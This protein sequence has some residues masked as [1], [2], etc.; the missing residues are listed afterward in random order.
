MPGLSGTADGRA[1]RPD[2]PDSAGSRYRAWRRGLLTERLLSLACRICQALAGTGCDRDNPDTGTLVRI[3]RDPP[4]FAHAIRLA[5]VI[6]ARPTIRRLVLD[7]FEPG[8]APPELTGD[9]R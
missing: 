9:Q 5:D 2:H 7:Q 6:R 1:A 3:D 4:L 8:T